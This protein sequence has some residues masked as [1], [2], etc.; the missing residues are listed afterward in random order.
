MKK[1]VLTLKLFFLLVSIT[2][3]LFL[4]GCKKSVSD[5]LVPAAEGGTINTDTLGVGNIP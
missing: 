3:A 2:T 1:R 5:P 4:S